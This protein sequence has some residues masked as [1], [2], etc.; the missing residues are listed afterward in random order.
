[1][2]DSITPLILTYN[3]ENNIERT[4]AQLAW[5]KRIVVIDSFSTDRTKEIAENFPNINFIENPFE[6]H[7]Q[8]WNF[9]LQ[10]TQTEWVLSLDADYI[11]T[12]ELIDEI[13]S[14]LEDSFVNSYYA[15]F[16]YCV[17]GKPLRGTIYPA[18]QVLFRKSKSTYYDDGH[19]QKLKVGGEV[20]FLNGFILH[21]DRKPLSRWL[22]AQDRYMLLERKH[23]LSKDFADLNLN[24]K[25]RRLI[26][27]APIVVFVYCYFLK[28]GILDRYH[29]L[30]YALQRMF[31][32]M[33]FSI[34]LIEAKIYRIDID[35]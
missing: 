29:G 20:D 11:V 31:A 8:Q 18:R 4:L 30:Y 27:F 2:L 15:S 22:V 3:E 28:G 17:N 1:M 19:T 14:L 26:I 7:A 24:D 10:Q 5:A 6:T 32:E 13:S 16:K 33:W 9:G 23:L 35:D 21:D 25:I 34:R 12:D